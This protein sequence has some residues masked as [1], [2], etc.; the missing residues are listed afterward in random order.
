MNL[1]NTLFKNKRTNTCLD[2]ITDQL[3]LMR[4]LAYRCSCH[5]NLMW[6]HGELTLAMRRGLHKKSSRLN[7]HFDLI[8]VRYLS[9][10]TQLILSLLFKFSVLH[11]HL[12]CHFTRTLSLDMWIV[13]LNIRILLTFLSTSLYSNYISEYTFLALASLHILPIRWGNLSYLVL[14][15]EV[16]VVW[17]TMLPTSEIHVLW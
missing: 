15:P 10:I 6:I 13:C 14:L 12:P 9:H 3:H 4:A 11:F 2:G 1:V 16:D 8:I 5:W 7:H 17:L